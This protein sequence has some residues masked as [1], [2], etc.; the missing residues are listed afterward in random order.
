MVLKNNEK[1]ILFDVLNCKNLSPLG[2]KMILSA[3]NSFILVI[4]LSGARFGLKSCA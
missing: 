2:I 3:T 1:P 4:K